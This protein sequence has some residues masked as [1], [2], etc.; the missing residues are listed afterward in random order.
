MLI[1]AADYFQDEDNAGHVL[2]YFKMLLTLAK[3]VL[4]SSVLL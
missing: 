3:Y 4:I 1:D 2:T